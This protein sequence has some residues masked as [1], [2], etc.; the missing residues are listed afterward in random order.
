[1]QLGA[2]TSGVY[3]GTIQ[4]EIPLAKKQIPRR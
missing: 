2:L 3:M 4:P 1:V